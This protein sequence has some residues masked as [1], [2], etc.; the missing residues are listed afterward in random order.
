MFKRLLTQR[1]LELVWEN[2]EIRDSELERVHLLFISM[3]TLN[4]LRLSEVNYYLN[5]YISDVPG[6]EVVNVTRLNL[7]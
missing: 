3:K 2:L 7:L 4:L 5:K 6:V 1:L